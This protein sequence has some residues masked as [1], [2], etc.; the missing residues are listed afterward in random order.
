MLIGALL[1]LYKA[2]VTRQKLEIWAPD[3]EFET[4]FGKAV[5]RKQVEAQWW[6]M[7]KMMEDV[8]VLRHKVLRNDERGFELELEVRYVVKGVGA[9]YVVE[10]VVEVE[11]D[12]S[13]EKVSRCVDKWKG[14]ESHSRI[15]EVS[16]RGWR[17]D[18]GGLLTM[19]RLLR[20][21]RQL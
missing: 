9:S 14:G 13:G 16:R 3:A 2:Q 20:E 17:C 5:G 10:S 6:A 11:V 12:E 19:N 4:I 18:K 21:R 15:L 7:D 1:D 8:R